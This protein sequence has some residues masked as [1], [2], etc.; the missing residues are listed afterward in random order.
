MNDMVKIRSFDANASWTITAE[1]IG[2]WVLV[3]DDCTS[4]LTKAG[5]E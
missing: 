4:G 1:G 2:P 5:A 3:G